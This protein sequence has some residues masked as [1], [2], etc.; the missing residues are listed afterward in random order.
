M[1][2]VIHINLDDDDEKK[3]SRPKAK[4]QAKPKTDPGVIESI[5]QL[6]A[7]QEEVSKAFSDASFEACMAL[8]G[9]HCGTAQDL[10]AK[11]YNA[12]S[13]GAYL[14]FYKKYGFLAVP[15][16]MEK[17]IN[18]E[19]GPL[20]YGERRNLCL[21]FTRL[22]DSEDIRRK[23]LEV[24]KDV[25]EAFVLPCDVIRYTLKMEKLY[26]AEDE[27]MNIRIFE[28]FER[29]CRYY[30]GHDYAYFNLNAIN[31]DVEGA[32]EAILNEMSRDISNTNVLSECLTSATTVDP[33][34]YNLMQ[35]FDKSSAEF[36][37]KH[38]G[39][40]KDMRAIAKDLDELEEKLRVFIGG[41]RY[42]ENWWT[43]FFSS[44]KDC[45]LS[46]KMVFQRGAAMTEEFINKGDQAPYSILYVPSEIT[47]II[48]KN[49]LVPMGD[50]R[51]EGTKY[52][53]NLQRM[54]H[55][56]KAMALE[57]AMTWKED[58]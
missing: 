2:N 25:P 54:T 52:A 26:T 12:L 37:E 48:K 32:Q 57:I 53:Q 21:F 41:F 11:A 45:L 23:L 13:S 55:R 42:D 43:P 28:D 8:D 24:L 3:P 50:T 39:F 58:E 6:E 38:W 5:E 49:E 17:Y 51:R 29:I 22:K 27:Q 7:M 56:L 30:R 19:E 4:A 15:E 9:T 14:S 46:V 36:H 33:S 10:I 35:I 31:F 47:E 1:G 40:E 20:D 18:T 34:V 16:Q 44:I